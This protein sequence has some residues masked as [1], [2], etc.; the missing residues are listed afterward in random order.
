MLSIYEASDTVGSCGHLFDKATD[1]AT[2][3]EIELHLGG[4]HGA[5]YRPH[6]EWI[7]PVVRWA[8]GVDLDPSASPR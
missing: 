2:T 6:S 1:P 5:F 3:A 4:G 8:G 7:D